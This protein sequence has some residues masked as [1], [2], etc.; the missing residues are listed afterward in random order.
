[1]VFRQTKEEQEK[2]SMKT[3]NIIWTRKL[4]LLRGR[5][6]F[7][8]FTIYIMKEDVTLLQ[9]EYEYLS[10]TWHVELYNIKALAF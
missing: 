6:Y 4:S 1:M 8:R 9:F 3:K 5:E 7:G 2:S 10:C